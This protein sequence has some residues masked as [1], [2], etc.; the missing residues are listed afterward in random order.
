[1]LKTTT[2]HLHPPHNFTTTDIQHP[3]NKS[4]L[5][6]SNQGQSNVG[7]RSL[8][9]SQNQRNHSQEEVD[10][11]TRHTGE[12]VRGFMPSMLRNPVARPRVP[13]RKANTKPPEGQAEELNRLQ[14][15]EVSL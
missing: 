10:E 11:M 4:S 9:E 2:S 3:Q 15:E 13:S 1:M 12:N 5:N 14:T 8:Y 6:M 7:F